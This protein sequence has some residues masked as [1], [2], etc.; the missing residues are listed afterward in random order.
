MLGLP[1]VRINEYQFRVPIKISGAVHS[2]EGN[3]DRMIILENSEE[4]FDE[5]SKNSRIDIWNQSYRQIAKE[6]SKE[7]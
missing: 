7:Y 1:K 4:T 3:W 2:D 6:S 5:P